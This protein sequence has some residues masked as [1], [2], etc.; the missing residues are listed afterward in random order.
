MFSPT[1]VKFKS[2]TPK[3]MKTTAVINK[4]KPYIIGICGGPS[5][6]MSTVAHNMQQLLHQKAGIAS[7]IIH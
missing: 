3:P 6:G 4:G 1:L 7:D 5:S 2:Y